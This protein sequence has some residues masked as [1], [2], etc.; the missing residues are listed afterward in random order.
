MVFLELSVVTQP[1][2]VL[3]TGGVTDRWIP[4]SKNVCV[5]RGVQTLR[6]AG[7]VAPVADDDLITTFVTQPGYKDTKTKANE[8]I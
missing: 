5:K 1:P 4:Q 6:D 2:T 7:V 3:E 8:L